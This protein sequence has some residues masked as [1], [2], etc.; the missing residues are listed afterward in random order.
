VSRA[1]LHGPAKEVG[2]WLRREAPTI[3]K[4]YKLPRGTGMLV[5]YLAAMIELRRDLGEIFEDLE[6]RDA[7]CKR[8]RKRKTATPDTVEDLL[9]AWDEGKGK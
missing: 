1:N 7:A 4:Y 2:A 5:L 9:R 3:R 6:T 8:T